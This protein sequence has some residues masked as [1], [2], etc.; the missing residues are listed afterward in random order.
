ME[1]PG[2]LSGQSSP[3]NHYRLPSFSSLSSNVGP[4]TNTTQAQGG[5]IYDSVSKDPGQALR[6]QLHVLKAE[7]DRFQALYEQL[8]TKS[9]IMDRELAALNEEREEL[10]KQARSLASQVEDLLKEKERLQHQSQADA[11]QWRQIMSMSSPLQMQ[12]VEET[13]RFNAEREAWIRERT[14]LMRRLSGMQ[15]PTLYRT[16]TGESSS[17]SSDLRRT[18][19]LSS[20]DD[21]QLR[22]EVNSLRERC[23]ELEE[24][25]TAVV[26]ES[27]SIERTGN[28]LREVRRRVASTAARTPS[29]NS[30]DQGGRELCR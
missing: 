10:R 2:G 11:S 12:S 17:V 27:A 24:L 8:E 18:L 3:T 16:D 25:L 28:L 14:M 20:M 13:R 21:D 6:Q 7:K 5:G 15:S 9:Y 30:E 23:T 4:P 19:T 26:K 22:Q 29:D 1:D